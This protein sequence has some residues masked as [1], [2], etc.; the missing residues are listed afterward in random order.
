[1]PGQPASRWRSADSRLVT[2]HWDGE[3]EWVVYSPRSGDVHLLNAAAHNLLDVLSTESLSSDELVKRLAEAA[4]RA[5]DDELRQA[6]LESL[7][8]LDAAGLVEPQ[9]P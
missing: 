7:A 8:S 6:V 4:G 3:D 2:R 5:A 1:M 9:R